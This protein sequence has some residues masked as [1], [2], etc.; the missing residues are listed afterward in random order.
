MWSVKAVLVFLALISSGCLT[1]QNPNAL[2]VAD[3]WAPLTGGTSGGISLLLCLVTFLA[4]MAAATGL[5][6][7]GWQWR[8]RRADS[9]IRRLE[10]PPVEVMP[11]RDSAANEEAKASSAEPSEANTNISATLR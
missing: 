2:V 5:I 4:G 10:G 1:I 6:W 8:R 7:I 3:G 11:R 9:E